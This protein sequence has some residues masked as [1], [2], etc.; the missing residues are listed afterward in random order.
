MRNSPQAH[1]VGATPDP[2]DATMLLGRWERTR[3]SGSRALGFTGR[4]AS[5]PPDV[6][7]WDPSGV[8]GEEA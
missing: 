2:V 1:G 7:S 8:M 4:V 6:M 5:L 3:G